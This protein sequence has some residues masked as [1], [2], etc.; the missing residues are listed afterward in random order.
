MTAVGRRCR[1]HP[2]CAPVAVACRWCRQRNT[3]CCP[4]ADRQGV[5]PCRCSRSRTGCCLA[6]NRRAAVQP[7]PASA[8]LPLPR[9]PVARVRVGPR[10][11]SPAS[12]R[13]GRPVATPGRPREVLVRVRSYWRPAPLSSLPS[14]SALWQRL[15]WPA[16]GEARLRR[17][18]SA[19]GRPAPRWSRTRIG[20]THQG[21]IAGPGRPCFLLRTPWRARIPGPWPLFSFSARAC[22]L[23]PARWC[24]FSSVH[25][26]RVPMSVMSP[27]SGQSPIRCP[28][29]R[30]PAPLPIVAAPTSRATHAGARPAGTPDGARRG[31]GTASRGV[32]MHR[33]P[34]AGR[35]G[36]GSAPP[37]SPARCRPRPLR[38]AAGRTCSHGPD[39]RRRF[40]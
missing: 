23:G 31:R 1:E 4:D 18:P 21:R 8:R 36:R 35:V 14:L 32:G 5:V 11:G 22:R 40:A 7:A 6:A 29:R 25:A 34:G 2:R 27:C 37:P 10:V 15:S 33:D 17:L 12:Q 24:A 38:L 13:P 3:D 28:G 9:R 20:R 26:H 30:P 19:Y 39:N 16:A